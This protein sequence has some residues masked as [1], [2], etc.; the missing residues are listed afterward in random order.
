[1]AIVEINPDAP[2]YNFLRAGQYGP[3]MTHPADCEIV[4]YMF[5]ANEP[6]K[7][8]KEGKAEDYA[9]LRIFVRSEEFGPNSLFHYE[10]IKAYS[11]SRLGEWLVSLGVPVEGEGFRHDTEQVIGRK[12]GVEVGEPREWDGKMYTGK[13]INIFGV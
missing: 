12:C 7:F 5:P 6:P 1:M 13:V 11:R 8:D 10:P 9:F 4:E 3:G 2:K